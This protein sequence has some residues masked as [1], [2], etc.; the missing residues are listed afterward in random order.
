M[1]IWKLVQK[2]SENYIKKSENNLA[3][4]H[5]F[6]KKFHTPTFFPEIFSHPH[7]ICSTRVSGLKKD[8]PLTE[9]HD[10]KIDDQEQVSRKNNLRVKR[11]V[12]ERGDSPEKLKDYVKGEIQKLNIE[13]LDGEVDRVHRVG[14]IY[15]PQNKRVLLLFGHEL[16]SFL[17]TKTVK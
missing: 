8:Q 11:L 4:P 6:Q 17:L 9:L 5:F 12:V 1:Q 7:N 16:I 13:I 2:I 15:Y 10:R 3:P 14:K